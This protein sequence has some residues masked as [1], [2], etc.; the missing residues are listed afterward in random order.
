[1]IRR[2][3]NNFGGAISGIPAP[4]QSDI[5]IKKVY[6]FVSPYNLWLRNTYLC[7]VVA[8]HT[9]GLSG[10]VVARHVPHGRLAR[11]VAFLSAGSAEQQGRDKEL[12]F[13]VP[14]RREKKIEELHS[15]PFGR[16][17]PAVWINF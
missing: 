1:M 12:H 16:T 7:G 8:A 9:C 17:E 2:Q 5:I 4:P 15:L 10:L 6:R 11:L 13:F 14:G 3:E